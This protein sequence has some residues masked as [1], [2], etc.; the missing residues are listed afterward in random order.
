M[1]AVLSPEIVPPETAELKSESLAL[2][3]AAQSVSINTLEEYSLMGSQDGP[4]VRVANV[5]KGIVFAFREPKEKAFAAH[6][7][8][9]KLEADLLAYP[10]EAERLYKAA[11]AKFYREEESRRREAEARE[12]ERLRKIEEERQLAEA[13]AHED[14]GEFEEAQAVFEQEVVAPVVEM[15]KPQAAGVSMRKTWGFEIV[16]P[17]AIKRA[18]LIPDE[19][20]IRALVKALGPDA[21]AQVGGIVVREELIPA[22]SAN[23]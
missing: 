21:A 13:I 6:K 19:K 18:F 16:S 9:C 4:L 23:G 10:K 22:V 17:D 7:A 14:A 5:I 11:M 1:S 12:R 15:P 20:R 8:I 2:V 3:K